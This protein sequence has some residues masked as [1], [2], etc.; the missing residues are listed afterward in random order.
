MEE[1]GFRPGSAGFCSWFCFLLAIQVCDHLDCGSKREQRVG[2]KLECHPLR[3]EGRKGGC[4]AAGRARGQRRC[5]PCVASPGQRE[6]GSSVIPAGKTGTKEE[7]P[8]RQN[9]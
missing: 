5:N 6:L 7:T 4:C 9:V 1:L 3:K 2:G 8:E